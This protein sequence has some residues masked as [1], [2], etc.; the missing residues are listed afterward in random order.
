[1]KPV[2]QIR[3]AEP[4]HEDWE[5]MSPTAQGKFC[6]ACQK[7]VID[8]TT[9]S[10]R[11][12]IRHIESK[13]GATCGRFLGSQLERPLVNP[14]EPSRSWWTTCLGLTT[15]FLFL[16][17]KSDAQAVKGKVLSSHFFVPDTMQPVP[18]MGKISAEAARNLWEKIHVG[19][20]VEDDKGNPIP[21]ASV[22]WKGTKIGTSTISDGHF[23]IAIQG[24]SLQ[25]LSISSIGFETR[26]IVLDTLA[27]DFKAMPLHI[28]LNPAVMGFM[29]EVVVTKKRKRKLAD[30][31]RKD[32][33]K[34][35]VKKCDKQVVPSLVIYPNPVAAGASLQLAAEH[36]PAGRYIISLLDISGNL[37]DTK[38]A[39]IDSGKMTLSYTVKPG[40]RP[41]LYVIRLNGNGKVLSEK[42]MVQ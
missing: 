37:I 10:D 17:S 25:I 36:L 13:K 9:L 21:G 24:Q 19:G 26:E 14:A 22:I 6:N 27:R 15:S 2:Y 8:F 11:E 7:Q 35:S 1:M 3:I 16:I 42:L 20:I 33:V 40:L 41:G 34:D 23:S 39:V 31:F 5:K 29:G 4:C 18:A 38:I 12:L 28:K 30:W 32:P